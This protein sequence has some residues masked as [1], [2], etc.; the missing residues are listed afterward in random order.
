MALGV[1]AACFTPAM[2]GN[3]HDKET[4]LTITQPVQVQKTVLQPGRYVFKLTEADSNH[5][6]VSIY[7]ADGMHLEGIVIGS[8]AYRN[9]AA[10]KTAFTFS[11][12]EGDQP[13]MLKSWF[14]PGDNFG[15]EFAVPNRQ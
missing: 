9:N 6:V 3:N 12:R 15:V 14:Y 2:K 1:C 4:Y 8:S 10:D 13:S 7:R 5:D 11:Q